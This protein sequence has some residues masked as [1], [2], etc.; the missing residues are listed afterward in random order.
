MGGGR[1]LGGPPGSPTA[2]VPVEC[3]TADVWSSHN[4]SFLGTTVHWIDKHTL[5]RKCAALA[6]SRLL[7]RHTYDVL[8]AA[9]ENIHNKYKISHKVISTVTDNGSNF[10]KA[11]SVFGETEHPTMTDSSQTILEQ[12]A[13][14]E[15]VFTEVYGLL[16]QGESS[17][18]EYSLPTHQRCAAHTLNLVAVHDSEQACDDG[19]YKRLFRS[20]MA[21]CAAL[22]NK[23]SRSTVS[24]GILRAS[25]RDRR[26][27]LRVS[28]HFR[29]DD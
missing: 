2:T 1:G 10:V 19:N 23:A 5:E 7:G 4:R 27:K 3:T 11:F 14:G 16:S 18:G 12:E 24:T 9:L 6:C 28:A 13:S 21:K 29:F 17:H 15:I 20:V 8:A 22:W 26:K 25:A